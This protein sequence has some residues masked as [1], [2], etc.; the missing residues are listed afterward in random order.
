M[1]RKT[2]IVPA[3]L[4]DDFQSLKKMLEQAEKFSDFVQ[5]DIM[6]GSFVPSKSI[7]AVDLANL[8][9]KIKWEAH[10]MVTNPLNQLDSFKKAGASRVIFHYEC[11]DSPLGV[12][13]QARKIGIEIGLAINPET[14]ENAFSPLIDKVDSLLFLTVNPGFYG[15]PFLPEVLTKI[16]E[17]R[18]KHADIEIEADG[19][20]KENN[21][22]K[23]ALAGVDSICVG[24]GIMLQP[25]PKLAYQKLISVL[26][27]SPAKS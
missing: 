26:S 11:S 21:I 16:A 18:R 24:S 6:D 25:D 8:S 13:S 1:I 7:T 4:T 27:S 10:L 17:T 20:I 12:I 19:G 14:R 2:R 22:L 15:S 3:I 23:V 5:I 9:I